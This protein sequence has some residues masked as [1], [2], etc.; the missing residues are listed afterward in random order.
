MTLIVNGKIEKKRGIGSDKY[1]GSEISISGMVY[2]QRNCCI[3]HIE[4]G[5]VRLSWFYQRLILVTIPEEAKVRVTISVS[6]F[7]AGVL[8]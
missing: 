4:K 2:Q 3:P 1:R 8:K 6:Y 7:L 5:I